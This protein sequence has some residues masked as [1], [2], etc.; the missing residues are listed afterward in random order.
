M[1]RR[2]ILFVHGLVITMDGER[3]I[4]EDGAVAVCQGKIAFVG[5]SAEALA[6]YPGAET[7][8]CRGA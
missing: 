7:V 5:P 4:L 8:D 2:P 6:Q 3:R 1:Q